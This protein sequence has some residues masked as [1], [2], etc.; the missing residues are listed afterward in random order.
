M[1]AA[2]DAATD[3]APGAKPVHRGLTTIA[4]MLATIMYALDWTIASVA[5]PHMQ[6]TFSATK[7]Q[8]S[9]V[10]TSY[11]VSSAVMIP[12]AGSLSR[13]FGRK[14]IFLFAMAAFTFTSVLCGMADSLAAEVMFR[15]L[16]GA[17]GAFLVP[18]SQAIVLDIYPRE[19]HGKAMAY[20]A[21]G[22]MMGPIL[23]PT[24]GGYLTEFQSWRW[25]F[26]INVPVGLLA[27]ALSLAFVPRTPRD[28]GHRF[29]WIGFLTLALGVGALQ[30]MLDR[31]ER[32][33]WF[34]SGEVIIE[35]SLVVL[36]FYLFI[37]HSL[38]TR[39]PF[40]NLKLLRDRNYA[41]GLCFIFLYGLL[42]L[43]PMVLMPP[44]LSELR[45]YPIVT[46][47]IVQTPRGIGL[48]TAALISGQLSN[49]VDPRILIG[50]GM[51]ALSLSNWAM[52]G[53]TLDVG[54]WEV[55]WTGYIAGFGAGIII[56]P[57]GVL[58]FYS[59]E[60]EHRTEATSVFN[61]VRSA[62]SSIGVSIAIAVLTRTTSV[63]HATLVEAVTPYSEVL[64]YAEIAGPWS[65][66][67]GPGLAALDAEITRQAA[68]IGYVNDFHMLAIGSLVGL[69]LLLFLRRPREVAAG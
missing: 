56:S 44:F 6:G 11:I 64:R 51:I 39:E 2:A 61:L 35:A 62:G 53:W 45:D 28:P 52:S 32:E 16:Q 26:Y 59:L 9:W 13:R 63:N 4:V 17:S 3:A 68:M 31:G 20:W 66:A 34:E 57:L 42:T 23:G 47:G 67:T 14:R 19:Q 55:M 8:I 38:T 18:I 58:T 69:P 48:L 60:A 12:T 33:A 36:G 40:L 15:I 41:I 54:S 37:V 10:I 49:R 5:L 50:I 65:L 27:F 1:T 24:I 22:V 43:A 29:D 30:M 46:I 21:M 7:D 25:I